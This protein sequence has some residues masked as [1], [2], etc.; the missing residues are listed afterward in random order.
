MLL[1]YTVRWRRWKRSCGLEVPG[2]SQQQ[3]T[4]LVANTCT[5]YCS[6]MSPSTD[7]YIRSGC[8]TSVAAR[9]RLVHD[10]VTPNV[11]KGVAAAVQY[12]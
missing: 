12:M 11:A 2:H 3:L 6:D 5:L 9:K 4:L 1:N 10:A 8:A 7:F